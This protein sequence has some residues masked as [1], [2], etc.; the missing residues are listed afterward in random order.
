MKSLIVVVGQTAIGKTKLAIELAK[1]FDGVVINADAMQV[2]ET[3]DIATAKVTEKEKD[4][5]EHF[6][7]D[8]VKPDQNFSVYEFKKQCQ[9]LIQKLSLENRRIIITGGSGLYLKALLYDYPLQEQS[10]IDLSV[11]EKYTNEQLYEML[12]KADRESAEILHQNNRARV[13]RALSL[14]DN[15]CKKSDLLAIQSKKPVYPLHL[16]GLTCHRDLLYDR[17]NTRV[18][19]M[20][21]QGLLDEA[22][23]M[24]KKYSHLSLTANQIIGYKEFYPYFAGEC[25]LEES[26]NKVKQHSRNLAK[27]QMTWFKNQMDVDW[28]DVD[29]NQFE[30]VVNKVINNIEEIEN[31]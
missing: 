26:I 17:I 3:L 20:M 25:T 19:M 13:L 12:L 5:V 9:D 2:Y 1:H 7:F 8:L 27:K 22:E 23:T 18:E 28:Y 16:I 10:K 11:Y 21:D 14:A 4:G 31:E 30:S 15:D 6:L 29:F 24:Y